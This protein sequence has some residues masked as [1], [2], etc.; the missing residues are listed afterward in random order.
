MGQQEHL[1]QYYDLFPFKEH[2]LWVAISKAEL[3]L[4]DVLR[5]E[6]QHY[7]RTKAGQSLRKEALSQADSSRTDNQ[8]LY[9]ML[10]DTYL[11][12]CTSEGGR[13]SH[14]EL[15]E[16][17]LVMAGVP[18]HDLESARPTVGNALGMSMYQTISA[19]GAGCHMLAA[20]EV[21]YFYAELSP[22]I[23]QAYT[24]HYG[25]S[26]EQARTYEIHGPMDK[27]H[28]ERAFAVLD[29]AIELNGWD[30]IDQSVRDAFAATSLHYDGMLEAATGDV[31]FWNGGRA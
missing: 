5:A 12:E 7:L 24:A 30:A 13:A 6:T 31:K 2:P 28:A 16:R 9:E 14:L 26:R 27:Q 19:R 20:G 25:M 1:L 11:D 21:E 3:P 10:F 18:K 8:R 29:E 23:F 22:E 17:L 4:A 15:I